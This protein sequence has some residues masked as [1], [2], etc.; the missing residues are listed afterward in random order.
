MCVY[1]CVLDA[2]S[3]VYVKRK[4]KREREILEDEYNGSDL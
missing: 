3:R 2:Y 4:K 1:V